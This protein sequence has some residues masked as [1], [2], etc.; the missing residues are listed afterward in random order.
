MAALFG[1][2]TPPWDSEDGKVLYKKSAQHFRQIAIEKK[3][4]VML[5]NHTLFDQGLNRIAYAKNRYSYMPN[6]YILGQK[7]VQDF[8]TLYDKL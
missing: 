7:G 8:I 1:G 4:D 3:V 2:A 6:I 5:S